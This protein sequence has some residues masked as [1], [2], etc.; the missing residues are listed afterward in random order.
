MLLATAGHDEK[1]YNLKDLGQ[2]FQVLKNR[3]K[4]I[5]VCSSFENSFDIFIFA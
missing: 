3:L 5:M 2:L 1:D 4:L